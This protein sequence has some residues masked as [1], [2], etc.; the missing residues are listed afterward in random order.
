M[1]SLATAV[2]ALKSFTVALTHLVFSSTSEG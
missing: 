2:F 1:G